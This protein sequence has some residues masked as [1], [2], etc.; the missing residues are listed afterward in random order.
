MSPMGKEERRRA[1]LEFLAG[2]DLAL[3]PKPIY[4][5][6][7]RQGA[8]FGKKTIE[9]HL[10]DMADEGLVERVLEAEGY[11]AITDKGL[12]YLEGD[13]DADD[14]QLPDDEE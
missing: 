12:A 2:C 6:M 10:G 14:L 7:S 8:T 13:L 9:R 5:N 3:P 4:V 11:Y 1:I